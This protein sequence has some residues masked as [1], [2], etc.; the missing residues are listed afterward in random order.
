MA[1]GCAAAVL[2]VETG[3]SQAVAQFLSA[4]QSEDD[5]A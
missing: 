4:G 2:G 3:R 5:H 1:R